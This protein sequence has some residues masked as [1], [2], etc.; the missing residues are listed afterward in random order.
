[1]RKSPY[2]LEQDLG[3]SWYATDTEGTG[4]KLRTTPE[5][6]LVEELP[7]AIGTE[8]K[9]LICRLKKRNWEL[10]R[11]VKEI[12]KRLAVSHQ[13]IGWSGT[14]DKNAVTTQ[15]ISLFDI[16]PEA[17]EQVRL[18]DIELTVVGRAN[19][20]LSLGS[21]AGNRFRLVIRDADGPDPDGQLAA[22]AAAAESGLPNYF[23]LQRFGGIRPVTHRVGELILNGDYEAAVMTYVGLAYPGESPAIQEARRGFF[24]SRDPLA[25]L[26]ALPVRMQ[27]ERSML[28]H[29][30]ANPGDYPGALR[31][32]P[33]KLLSMFVSAF[34][35]YLF[36][37]GLS[38]RMETG[39]GL[40]EP[41]PG[42]RLLFP[43]GKEDQVTEGNLHA[44]R[45][46]LSRGRC[47]IAIM[48]PGAF[49]EKE[50]GVSDQVIASILRERG[51]VPDAFAQ[52]AD[53]VHAK[54]EGALRPATLATKIDWS[55]EGDAINLAFDLPPGHY[56]TTVCR[57]V[58][59]APPDSMI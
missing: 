1:M 18:A 19:E 4:G 23:G 39:A 22:V 10:Q 58:M 11:A 14:K 20:P 32:L 51:I 33:P 17:V 36:N 44:A 43:S 50:Y 59:K 40:D 13:R 31:S 30:Q 41:L 54:F 47:R 9:Y 46:H 29:L 57:E 53:F 16:A 25:A 38:A 56:A 37:R 42:D 45:Q 7:L 35:S 52:A 24:E 6:F 5:D 34:Q 2:P 55:R 26:H 21:L 28:H 8:G 49:P 27:W 15:Y 3:M 48:M 12:A